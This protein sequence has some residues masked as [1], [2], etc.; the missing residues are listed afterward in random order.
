MPRSIIGLIAVLLLAP[1]GWGQAIDKQVLDQLKDSTVFIKLKVPEVGEASGSGFVI[2]TTGDTVLI[3]TNRHV[4]VPDEGDLP[5]RVRST[6][7]G[8]S[9]GAARPSSRSCRPR[10]WPMTTARSATWPCSRS[11]ACRPLPARSR[12]I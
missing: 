6:S 4:V 12:R 1:S 10:S 7:S 9:S 8:W 5:A 3:M 2:R 11:R